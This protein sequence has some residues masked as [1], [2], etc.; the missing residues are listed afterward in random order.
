M[1]AVPHVTVKAGAQMTHDD[2][3]NVVETA[4][5]EGIGE[6]R[7]FGSLICF[8]RSTLLTDGGGRRAA[9]GVHSHYRETSDR[10]TECL[11]D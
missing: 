1:N 6:R 2:V 9:D 8:C 3:E 5:E 11:T 4:V 10:L 7:C